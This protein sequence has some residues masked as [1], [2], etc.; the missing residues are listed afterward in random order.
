MRRNPNVDF[1]SRSFDLLDSFGGAEASNFSVWS[2][3][4]YSAEDMAIESAETRSGELV[5]QIEMFD[6]VYVFD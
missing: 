5:T 3:T 1:F 6:F 4:L 2:G